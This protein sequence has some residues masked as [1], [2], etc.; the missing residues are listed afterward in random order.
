[1]DV[2]F[3]LIL[4]LPGAYFVLKPIFFHEG[5]PIEFR[6]DMQ[7]VEERKEELIKELKRLKEEHL[8]GNITSKDYERLKKS[9]L[10]EL[11][12]LIK[13]FDVEI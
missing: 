6:E 7:D 1:M 5:N 9:I 2:I 8:R 4:F 13:K 12:I 10:E 11:Y 3:F